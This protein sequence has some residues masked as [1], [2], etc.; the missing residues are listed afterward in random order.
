MLKIIDLLNKIARGEETPRKFKYRRETFVY[1]EGDYLSI[2]T[3][4]W[5]SE[6]YLFLDNLNDEVEIIEEKVTQIEKISSISVPM[7]NND[8]EKNIENVTKTLEKYWSTINEIIAVI[9]DMRDKE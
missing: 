3:N 9:N 5:F 6:C 8:R 7:I 2:D 4:V 1:L